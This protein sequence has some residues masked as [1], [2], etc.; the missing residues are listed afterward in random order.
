MYTLTSAI[1]VVAAFAGGYEWETE[2]MRGAYLGPGDIN[3]VDGMADA[4]LNT[5]IVKF[6]GLESPL[7]AASAAQLDA[8]A[9]ACAARGIRFLPCFNFFGGH[10][11]A[12]VGEYRHYVDRDGRRYA[13]TPCPADADFWR[14]TVRARFAL[15]AARESIPGAVLDLEMYGAE[16][17]TYSEPCSCGHCSQY[18]TQEAAIAAIAALAAECRDAV[19]ETRP[20][21]LL[22]GL[23]M[24]RTDYV[25]RACALGLSRA[26]HPAIAFTESTYSP[27]YSKAVAISRGRLRAEANGCLLCCGLWQ[28]KFPADHVAEQLYH[29]AKDSCGYWVYTFQTFNKPTYSPLPDPPEGYWAAYRTANAE[30]D[31]L[32]RDSGYASA[33]AVREFERPAPQLRPDMLPAIDAVP[34]GFPV[35]QAPP[36]RLRGRHVLCTCAAAGEPVEIHV[37]NVRLGRYT[38][39]AAA[40]MLGPDGSEAGHA[41]LQP[42]EQAR[43]EATYPEA[44]RYRLLVDSGGNTVRVQ[45]RG[46]GWAVAGQTGSCL[47]RFRATAHPRQRRNRPACASRRRAAAKGCCAPSMMRTAQKSA[48]PALSACRTS[49]CPPP[50]ARRLRS[51]PSRSKMPLSRT[52]HWASS[53]GPSRLLP[54]RP[55]D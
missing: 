14:R 49:K 30:L 39:A 2:K 10:E 19:L 33:L 54:L 21:F 52:L 50:R 11:A 6:G 9:G 7:D 32:A 45:R 3:L 51:K 26:E 16:T 24:D 8:W 48:N 17:T 25:A 13:K 36:V 38:D 4:G 12:W 23:L 28:S 46:A 41:E 35:T 18:A 44:G 29:L 5:A 42:E 43:F 15:L 22:G 40:L 47:R 34:A 55:A 37:A 53:P 27:G 20:D 31:L 1:M